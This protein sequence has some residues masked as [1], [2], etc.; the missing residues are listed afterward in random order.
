MFLKEHSEDKAEILA[1][2]SGEKAKLKQEALR[3]VA[4]LQLYKTMHT[5]ARPVVASRH[6]VVR[7]IDQNNAENKLELRSSKENAST[8]YESKKAENTSSCT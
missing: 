3:S 8:I 6:D 7:N 5:F 2:M 4:Y 1:S